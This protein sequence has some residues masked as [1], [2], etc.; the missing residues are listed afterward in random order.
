MV[1]AE[2]T[3]ML[4]LFWEVREVDHLRPTP[5]LVNKCRP[6]FAKVFTKLQAW[7]LEEFSRVAL[8]DSDLLARKEI[9]E[10]FSFPAQ[11][12]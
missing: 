10:I 3:A 11:P 7:G 4:E 2:A 5:A 1:Q 9:Y 6:R 12:R 8:L